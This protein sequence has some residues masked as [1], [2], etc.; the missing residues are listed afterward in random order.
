MLNNVHQTLLDFMH[1]DE[2]SYQ[3][4]S[5][6][7]I[8]FAFSGDNGQWRGNVVTDEEDRVITSMVY[9]PVNVPENKFAKVAELITRINDNLRIGTFKLD[10]SDGEVRY[11]ITNSF[12]GTDASAE[13]CKDIVYLPN[14][15]L[16]RY[17]QFFMQ[18]IYTET[19]AEELYEQSRN[20]K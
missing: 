10:Y 6:N 16:N 1:E 4:L 7:R 3:V 19:S 14:I 17:F 11:N 15:M 18:A 13:V 20:K 8:R 2:W 12:K 5:E 9:F